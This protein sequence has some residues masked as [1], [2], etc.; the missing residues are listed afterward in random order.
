MHRVF[1][2]IC[3]IVCLPIAGGSQLLHCRHAG[4]CFPENLQGAA[5]L[6]VYYT[7]CNDIE[8]S[9]NVSCYNQSSQC[10]DDCSATCSTGPYGFVG[11]MSWYAPCAETFVVR[12]YECDGCGSSPL[13]SPTP[14][15]TPT[16]TPVLGGNPEC[17]PNSALAETECYQG[18][19]MWRDYPECNC[20]YWYQHDPG[21]PILVDINGDGFAL[22]DNAGGVNF[23]LNS[24]GLVERLS[25]TAAGSD[26]AWLALD[27]NGSGSIDNGAELFGN[28]T[29]QPAPPNATA[30]SLWP[31]M[32][33]R[34]RAAMVTECLVRE[35]PSSQT[36]DCGRTRIITASR[37]RES[38]LHYRS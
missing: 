7:D 18:G 28:F 25:W 23:D 5:F 37:K 31:N 38:C 2:I 33:R 13:N 24:D 36:L 34:R 3:F 12:T 35:M 16:P 1:I 6:K 22:I 27:R 29:P 15:P 8:G 9:R 21:S 26:D 17:G 14:T 30:F 32:T 11:S 10:K 19:G 4:V 20:Y